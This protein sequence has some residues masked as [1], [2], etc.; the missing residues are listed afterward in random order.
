VVLCVGAAPSDSA[1]A[2]APHG[3]LGVQLSAEPTARAG[4]AISRIFRDGPAESAGLREGD[5]I[6]RIDGVPVA[7]PGDVIRQIQ[8]RQPGD[9]APL[10]VERRGKEL[11]LSV[12]LDPRP[13]VIR[14]GDV[15]RG[16]IGIEAIDLP[17]ALRE[18]FGAPRE[19]GVMVSRVD[20][21]S[22]ASA[23]GFELGDV[24]YEVDGKSLPT[25]ARLREQIAAGGVG[26]TIELA[27]A[28]DSV[29]LVLEARIE[30]APEETARP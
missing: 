4:A 9:W 23:A 22:P 20:T 7:G 25:P 30:T 13:A 17:P 11:D 21:A 6:V 2:D 14:P 5:V 3:W 27:V 18:H 26:N 15:R 10:A 19:A 1:R 24:V 8:L 16:W 12:R 29:E 28:R